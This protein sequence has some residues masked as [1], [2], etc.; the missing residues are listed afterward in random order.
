[1]PAILESEFDYN[2]LVST[3]IICQNEQCDYKMLSKN[4]F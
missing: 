2:A 1:M 4:D 3:D